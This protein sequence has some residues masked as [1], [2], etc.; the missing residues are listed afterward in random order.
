MASKEGQSE[1]LSSVLDE[2]N[3]ILNALVFP[4]EKVSPVSKQ[5]AHALPALSKIS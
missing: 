3:L 5:N 2:R 1:F 4:V